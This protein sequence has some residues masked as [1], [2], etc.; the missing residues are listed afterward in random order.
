MRAEERY[1]AGGIK[2]KD[3]NEIMREKNET[4]TNEEEW[5]CFRFRLNEIALKLDDILKV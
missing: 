4:M 3:R 5:N 2:W 1:G